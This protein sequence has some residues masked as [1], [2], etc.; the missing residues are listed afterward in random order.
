MEE[1]GSAMVVVNHGDAVSPGAAEQLRRLLRSEETY[2]QRWQVHVRRVTKAQVHQSAVA[3]V[4]VDYLRQTGELPQS[5]RTPSRTMRE[6]VTRSLGGRLT[7][8]GLEQFISAFEITRAHQD[9]LWR[10]FARDLPGTSRRRRSAGTPRRP[11][12]PATYRSVSLEDFH[13]VGPDRLPHTHR[14]VHVVR[15]VEPMD[16]YTYRFDT[17][18][19]AIDVVRGGRSSDIYPADPPGMWAIDIHLH[20]VVP[21]GQTAVLEYRTVFGYDAPP[22]P[23]FRRGVTGTVGTLAM[24]VQ[25]HPAAVPENVWWGRWE[26]LH[27]APRLMVPWQVGEG[28]AAVQWAGENVHDQLVGFTWRW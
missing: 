14:T 21:P 1:S 24:E 8:Q 9:Q 15:A 19:V 17:S 12:N 28:R 26:T 11:V 18:A 16:R 27:D 22:P 5:T 4:L 20:D 10:S 3:Q 13:V 6:S 25:F 7:Q 23:E 2:R